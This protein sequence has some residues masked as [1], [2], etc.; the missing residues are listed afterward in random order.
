MR[1]PGYC[2]RCHRVRTVRVTGAALARAR[3]GIVEG[4][5][6]ECEDAEGEAT[7]R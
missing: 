6:A 2:T 3:G 5:C 1:V 7:A 4:V